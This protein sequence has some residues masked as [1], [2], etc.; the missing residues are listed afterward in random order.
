[1]TPQILEFLIE[2]KKAT[3]AGKGPEEASS[4]PESHDLRYEKD[5]LLYIDTYLGGRYFAGEEALW[6]KGKSFWAMNYVGRVLDE[7]FEGDFLKAALAKVP[8][9]MPY[10]GP[11]EFIQGNF[12]YQN[13]VTGDFTWFQGEEAI[14][15]G[16]EKVYECRYHGGLIE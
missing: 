16:S 15:L 13:Q 2:A 8:L 1:M 9:E 5:D 7:R 4:R 14:F 12:I 6:K 3:Y 10:R 11:K